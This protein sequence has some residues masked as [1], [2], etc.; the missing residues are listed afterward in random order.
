[1]ITTGYV[2]PSA[3]LIV[4][5]PVEESQDALSRPATVAVDTEVNWPCALVVIIGTSDAEP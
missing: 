5:V 4:S 1:M 3:V 2:P